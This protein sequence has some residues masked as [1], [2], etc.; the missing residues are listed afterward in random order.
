MFPLHAPRRIEDDLDASALMDA[1]VKEKV[2]VRRSEN[3]TL[4][5][6]LISERSSSNMGSHMAS[7]SE[8]GSGWVGKCVCVDLW[9]C[10]YMCVCV[11]ARARVHVRVCVCVYVCVRVCVCVFV[12]VCVCVCECM[13]ACACV[14]ECV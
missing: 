9:M 2:A 1:A 10:M 6:P 4:T 13:C 14:C 11:C 7:T 3:D 5:L 12:C 8:K